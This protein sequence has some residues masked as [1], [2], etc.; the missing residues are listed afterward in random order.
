CIG[1]KADLLSRLEERKTAVE[2]KAQ[3]DEGESLPTESENSQEEP[4]DHAAGDS[5]KEKAEDEAPIAYYQAIVKK[6]QDLGKQ[7]D[8]PYV[9]MELDNLSRKWSDGPEADSEEMTKLYQKFTRTADNFEKR[10][11][12]HYEELNK[13]KQKNFETKKRLLKEFEGIISNETWTATKRVSQ[14]KGQWNST[15]AIPS[16]KGEDFDTRFNELL[17]TYNDHK[18]DRLVQQR[19]KREDNLMIKLTVLEKMERVN[20][21]IDHETENWDEIDEKF[22]ALTGQWQKIGRVP[23]EKAN[24]AWDRYK[25]AQDD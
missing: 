1:N 6:A 15:G 18:V 14:M 21:S 7:N 11:E 5:E 23:Q 12:E 25:Q 10:K 4:T 24:G 13:Q 19:Q 9:S 17:N 8:W 3:D 22:D 20:K 2:Q 16:G